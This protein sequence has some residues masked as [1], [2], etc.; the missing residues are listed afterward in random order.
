MVIL[1]AELATGRV[2]FKGNP[3][4]VVWEELRNASGL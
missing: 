3:E 4:N 2:A 1:P